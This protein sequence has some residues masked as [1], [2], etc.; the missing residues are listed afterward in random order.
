MQEKRDAAG[1]LLEGFDLA[2]VLQGDEIVAQAGAQEHRM[3]VGAVGDGVGLLE[4][5]EEARIVER[6]AGHALAR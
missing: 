3:D 5:I 1:V 2:I 6:N 4:A